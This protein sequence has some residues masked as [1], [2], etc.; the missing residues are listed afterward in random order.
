MSVLIIIPAYNE[1]ESIVSTVQE[2]LSTRLDNKWDYVVI[3]DGSTD[4]TSSICHERG[5]NV[6]DLPVNL[7]LT[8]A[9]QTGMKYAYLNAF[10]AAIQFDADGQHIPSH[11]DDLIALQRDSGADIIIGSRFVNG[12]KP[13][14]LRM[15]GNT[16]ISALIKATTGAVIHDPTSGMRLYNSRMIHEFA[17]RTD[18]SPE[19]DTLAYL[20]KKKNAKVA[21]CQVSMRERTAGESYLTA[22]K[23]IKYMVESCTSIIFSLWF[24]R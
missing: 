4:A 21:E 12:A 22:T 11:I 3:N 1:E 14:S 6:I 5:F 24:R 15:A 19:P 8:G 20:I 9:F 23:A 16:L 7:G 17:M 13:R 2:L 18:L 10:D